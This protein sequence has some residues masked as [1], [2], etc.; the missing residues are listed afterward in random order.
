MFLFTCTCSKLS[1]VTA[2]VRVPS[3]QLSSS[4]DNKVKKR[5]ISDVLDSEII[6]NHIVHVDH[7]IHL[8]HSVRSSLL[9]KW[10]FL[11]KRIY[12]DHTE[13]YVHSRHVFTE[14]NGLCSCLMPSN[15]TNEKKEQRMDKDEVLD[16]SQVS[17]AA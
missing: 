17:L 7:F 2:A 13:F 6:K 8:I 11:N 9:W 16:G 3:W 4:K 10:C 1:K 12:F 5:R 15:Q 14:R